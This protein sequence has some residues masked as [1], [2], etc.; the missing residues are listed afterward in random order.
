[1]DDLHLIALELQMNECAE[2]NFMENKFIDICNSLIDELQKL[3]SYMIQFLKNIKSDISV[4]ASKEAMKVKLQ[5]LRLLAKRGESVQIPDFKRIE[6]IYN[7]ACKNLP[8]ELKKLLKVGY[9]IKTTSD[10]EKF[11]E[12]K[13]EFENNLNNLENELT[14]ITKEKS[15]YKAEEAYQILTG[16]LKENSIYVNTYYKA[17][18]EFDRFK[19]DYERILADIKRKNDSLGRHNL[20]MHK[21]LVAKASTSLS[22][23]LK[24][25][26]FCI[27]AITL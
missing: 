2:D 17:I 21:S 10:L 19:H 9:P 7:N 3:I 16:L 11:K 5:R 18:Q 4:L 22:R 12:K 27:T 23:M 26:V 6:K 25:C 1:M 8:K 20:Q 15:L 24:K 14:L 13:E